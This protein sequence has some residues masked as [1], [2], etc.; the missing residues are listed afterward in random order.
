MAADRTVVQFFGDLR[1][2]GRRR[3]T[4]I[5]VKAQ[6][7]VLELEAEGCE[8]IRGVAALVRDE[9]LVAQRELRLPADDRALRRVVR[10]EAGD[11]DQVM[12]DVFD[13]VTAVETM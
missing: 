4:G 3:I 11:R 13:P 9:V 6:A 2:A 5:A 1:V 8:Q 12:H 10:I 7:G